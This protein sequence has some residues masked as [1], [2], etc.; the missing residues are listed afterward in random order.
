MVINANKTFCYR[1][2]HR[3]NLQHILDQGLVNKN[4]KNAAPNFVTIGNPEIIDVR[5]TTEVGLKGYGN[6]GDYIPFY[7]TPRS[8]MLY[9]CHWL[10]CT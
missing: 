9:N 2:T 1:I 5:S 7:F 3:D 6:I 4:H 10:L 8:I